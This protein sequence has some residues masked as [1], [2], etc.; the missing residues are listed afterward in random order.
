[1]FCN[2]DVLCVNACCLQSSS[3][4]ILAVWLRDL[5]MLPQTPLK[6][7]DQCHLRCLRRLLGISWED[8]VTNQEVLRRS[9]MPGVEVLIMKAQLTWTG[10]VMRMEDS[11]LPKQIF[12]SQPDWLR[13]LAGRVA[14][15]SATKTPSRTLRAPVTSLLKAGNILQQIVQELCASRGGRPAGAVRPNEPSGFRG[16]TAILNHAHALVSACP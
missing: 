13:A 9:S 11:R 4:P 2:C 6:K 8:R 3:P 5:D 14:R 12:C 1:M 7:L 10:H 16:R 15:Q